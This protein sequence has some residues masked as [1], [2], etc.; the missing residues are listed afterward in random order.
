M[1]PHTGGILPQENNYDGNIIN[2]NIGNIHTLYKCYYT[3]TLTNEIGL[4]HEI[5]D[6]YSNMVNIDVLQK[7]IEQIDKKKNLY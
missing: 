7:V 2:D 3:N 4:I 6:M 5:G 1:N